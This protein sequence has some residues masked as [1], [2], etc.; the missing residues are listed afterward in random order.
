M[1]KTRQEDLSL[2]GFILLPGSSNSNVILSAPHAQGPSADEATGEI[3]ARV[4]QVTKSHAL[5]STRSR[6]EIDPN[7]LGANGQSSEYRGKLRE[8]ILTLA[9]THDDVLLLDVH[10]MKR[11]ESIDSPAVLLG[12]SMGKTADL[13]IVEL[14]KRTF[15]EVGITACPAEDH[16][17]GLI[18]GGIVNEAADLG[19]N[20]HAIQLEFDPLERSVGSSKI[21]N[22]LVKII[23]R[24]KYG[25]KVTGA[26]SLAKRFRGV[27]FPI[28][29]KEDLKRILMKDG[30]E[31]S[32]NQVDQ[33]SVL[34]IVESVPPK[35]FP[36][37]SAQLTMKVLFKVIK[38]LNIQ[39][40]FEDGK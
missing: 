12:T 17:Y 9:Q 1:V 23:R 32:M 30:E 33:Y 21:G 22:A 26:A 4:A 10:G 39:T 6:L 14:V 3:V 28:E 13:E 5:I 16:D 15:L 35:S 38:E 19:P 7:S 40:K 36:L 25:R 8:L 2:C 34:D 24:W 29:T 11:R 37:E 31:I 18:G 27:K 20:I